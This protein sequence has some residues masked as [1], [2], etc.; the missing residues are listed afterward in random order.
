MEQA[1][2]A[3]GLATYMDEAMDRVRY[4]MELEQMD[5]EIGAAARPAKPATDIA[6][7]AD[8]PCY[9]AI[10]AFGRAVAVPYPKTF[11]VY[12]RN[13]DEAMNFLRISVAAADRCP[14]DLANLRAA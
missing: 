11:R 7:E 1:T 9:D 13:A 8:V 14:A 12:A 3:G 2:M 6:W 5:S 10:Y 4:Q